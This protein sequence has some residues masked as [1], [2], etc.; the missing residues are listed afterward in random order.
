ML[1]LKKYDKEELVVLEPD[2]F[3]ANIV[4]RLLNPDSIS[5]LPDDGCVTV[6]H[7]RSVFPSCPPPDVIRLLATMDLC[8]ALHPRQ[9][10]DVI[11]PCLDRSEDA[12]LPLVSGVQH[13]HEVNPKRHRQHYNIIVI[14]RCF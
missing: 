8:A 9:D 1:L 12:S 7:L 14:C 11:I 10:N 5:D 3:G 2:W 4:G 13:S 6:D